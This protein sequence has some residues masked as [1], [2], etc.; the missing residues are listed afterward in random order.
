MNN[1]KDISNINYPL[2]L[3]DIKNI[4]KQFGFDIPIVIFP[5]IKTINGHIIDQIILYRT[6]LFSGHWTLLFK[7]NDGNIEY[8]DSYGYFP[9][10]ALLFNGNALNK[11]LKMELP[12]VNMLLKNIESEYNEN[13]YQSNNSNTCGKW[14]LIRYLLKYMSNDEFKKLFWNKNKIFNDDVINQLFIKLLI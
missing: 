7:N 5:N 1:L 6:K 14:V 10:K 8:F 9:D 12:I 2:T 11:K 13:D 4:S 3:K